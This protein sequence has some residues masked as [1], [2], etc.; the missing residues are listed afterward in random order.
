MTTSKDHLKTV[1]PLEHVY[2]YTDSVDVR[3]LI[4]VFI[5]LADHKASKDRYIQFYKSPYIQFFSTQ[6]VH[7][8][9]YMALD[10]QQTKSQLFISN[11]ATSTFTLCCDVAVAIKFS[12]PRTLFDIAPATRSL[13]G[14]SNP[15]YNVFW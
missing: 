11:I 6:I 10:S 5:S 1:C 12:A 9:P 15:V 8:N 3:I 14:N 7:P 13:A 4:T 2:T